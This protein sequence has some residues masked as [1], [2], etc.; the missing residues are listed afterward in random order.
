MFIQRPSSQT[1]GLNGVAELSCAA[2]GSPQPTVF[3][4]REGDQNLMFPGTSH[5]ILQVEEVG[6]FLLFYS[7]APL[8]LLSMV[9]HIVNSFM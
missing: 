4:T 3:W 8:K 7:Q 9:V 6:A 2:T 1:V 5:G